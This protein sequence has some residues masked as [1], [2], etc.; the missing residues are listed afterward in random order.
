MSVD[1]HP[2]HPRSRPLSSPLLDDDDDGAYGANADADADERQ[3]QCCV[4]AVM[5]AISITRADL[6]TALLAVAN[7]LIIFI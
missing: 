6:L 4:R 1:R 5:A 2:L 7:I 3:R